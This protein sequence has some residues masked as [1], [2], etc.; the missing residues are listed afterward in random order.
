MSHWQLKPFIFEDS[1]DGPLAIK[2][3]SAVLLQWQ[4]TMNTIN[5]AFQKK[6]TAILVCDFWRGSRD[7]R[8]KGTG[9]YL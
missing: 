8:T 6:F 9:F 2:C 5:R 1:Q 3:Y 4:Q 7:F